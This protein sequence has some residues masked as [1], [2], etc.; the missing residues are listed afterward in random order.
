MIYRFQRKGDKMDYTEM[1]NKMRNPVY[2]KSNNQDLPAQEG[3][4]MTQSGQII[5][6]GNQIGTCQGYGQMNVLRYDM[7]GKVVRK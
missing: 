1:L 5:R 3:M 6:D 2:M 4:G 7:P